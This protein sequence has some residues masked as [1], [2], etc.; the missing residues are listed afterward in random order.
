MFYSKQK[1][2]R[3]KAEDYLRH[4]LSEDYAPETSSWGYE[5]EIRN[6]FKTKFAILLFLIKISF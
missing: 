5:V 4:A 1:I 3:Q 2:L 6:T